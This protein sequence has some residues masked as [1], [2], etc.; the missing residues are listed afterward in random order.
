MNEE[1][2]NLAFFRSYISEE[3]RDPVTP[4][5]MRY[6][7]VGREYWRASINAIPAGCAYKE[8]LAKMVSSLH[9][10]EI[11]GKGAIFYGDQGFGKTSSAVIMLKE[12]LARGGQGYFCFAKNM[13]AFFERPRDHLTP[14]GVPVWEMA[15]RCHFFILDD[16]GTELHAAGYKAGN[17]QIIETLIRTRYNNRLPTYITT[18]LALSEW[19]ESYGAFKTILL[20]DKRFYHVKVA[21]KNWRADKDRG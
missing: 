7:N 12:A 19:R 20:D 3:R 10:D 21:G 8:I 18:N 17:T 15:T 2:D 1:L 13:D 5:T 9:T 4:T 6:A 14:E 16:L 11:K